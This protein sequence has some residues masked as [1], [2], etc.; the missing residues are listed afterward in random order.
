MQGSRRTPMFGSEHNWLVSFTRT[1]NGATRARL[2]GT[3]LLTLV[4]ATV[5]FLAVALSLL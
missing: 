2:A 3:G 4:V 1:A 5:G